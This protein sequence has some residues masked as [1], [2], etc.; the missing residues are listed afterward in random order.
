MERNRSWLFAIGLVVAA[1]CQGA[2]GVLNPGPPQY[3]RH[4]SQQFDPYPSV[5]EGPEVVGGRPLDYQHPY[6]EVSRSQPG[7][8]TDSRWN[9]RNWFG[10]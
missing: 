4:V 1:G 6:S 10:P 5:E 8:W 3:Q 7:R 2:P 9:P